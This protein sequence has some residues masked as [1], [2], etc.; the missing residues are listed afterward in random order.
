MVPSRHDP[1]RVVA[2]LA[3]WPSVV[4]AWAAEPSRATPLPQLQPTSG[5]PFLSR[6]WSHFYVIHQQSPLNLVLAYFAA[7]MDL[8]ISHITRYG[9]IENLSQDSLASARVFSPSR[10]GS[11]T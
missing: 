11:R 1:G 10:S 9:R 8:T 2:A 3:G 4:A 7:L 6:H 5:R